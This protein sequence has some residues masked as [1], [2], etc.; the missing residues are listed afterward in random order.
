MA[1]TEGT[2]DPEVYPES[3]PQSQPGP[4][5]D[6]QE[7]FQ[8]Q[9]REGV[10][11]LHAGQAGKAIALLEP[12]HKRRQQDVEVALNLGGAYILQQ[13]YAE[14]RQVLEPATAHAPDN[15]NLWVNLAAARLGPLEEST[16]EQQDEAIAAYQRALAANDQAANVHY[17]LGLIYRARE[18]ELRA[19]AHF[20]RALEQNP[21]DRDAQRMLSAIAKDQAN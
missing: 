17:M 12:L 14:A 11:L 7:P 6:P 21:E 2:T 13:R 10:R 19:A 8:D 18:E 3:Q 16:R 4:S 1:D 9:F 5:S 20:T 15:A